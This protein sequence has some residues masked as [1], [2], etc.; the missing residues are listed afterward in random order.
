MKGYLN[1]NG[2]N[3]IY[4]LGA[5]FSAPAGFPLTKNLLKEVHHVA[6]KQKFADDE[7]EF[8]QAQLLLDTLRF[9]Y[10]LANF[11]HELILNDQ[12]PKDFDIE[13]FMSYVSVESACQLNTGE[14]FNEHGSQF[15]SDLKRWIAQA[16]FNH[17][18]KALRNVPDFYHK[19]ISLTKNSLIFT[20]NWDTFLETLFEINKVRYE[21][22]SRHSLHPDV[23][24]LFKLH[25]SI[26]WFSCP[27]PVKRKK[28]MRFQ[29]LGKT[30]EGMYRGSVDGDSLDCF[31]E[32]FLTPWIV[33]PAYDKIDQIKQLGGQWGLLY[34]FFQSE[35]EVVIIGFSMRDDDY[36]SRAIIYPQLVQGSQQGDLSVKVVSFARSSEEKEE[37]KNKFAGIK[38]CNFFFDGFSNKAIEFITS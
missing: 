31:Y 17:E 25:G 5:G 19:F 20:F 10:P 26:D 30:F 22:D 18:K 9:Y 11:S 12:L 35:L 14:Q 13:K 34:M 7:T 3:R 29:A 4:I 37:I 21:L 24:P 2:I 6:S 8:G 15:V 27:H 28:W 32:A 23:V 38:N 36:H 1:L 33:V 16:I